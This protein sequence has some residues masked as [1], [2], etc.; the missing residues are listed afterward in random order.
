MVMVRTSRTRVQFQARWAVKYESMGSPKCQPRDINVVVYRAIFKPH[1]SDKTRTR[2][3]IA[4]RRVSVLSVP[5][6]K[7]LKWNV[8]QWFKY[9]YNITGISPI[10]SNWNGTEFVKVR[11]R[12]WSLVSRAIPSYL[13][14]FGNAFAAPQPLLLC[15]GQI[16]LDPER[17]GSKSWMQL[18]YFVADHSFVANDQLGSWLHRSMLIRR[19]IKMWHQFNVVMD[20]KLRRNPA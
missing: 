3:W 20:A 14:R 17:I 10:T 8:F 5:K 1:L 16:Q 11:P 2:R 7:A 13:L 6:H 9:Y 12:F 4:K 19:H 15:T 18:D